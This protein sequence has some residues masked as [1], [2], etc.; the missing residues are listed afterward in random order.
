[1]GVSQAAQQRIN[2]EKQLIEQIIYNPEFQLDGI[3]ALPH[4]DFL[5]TNSFVQQTA[6]RL[7]AKNAA[8]KKWFALNADNQ[9]RLILSPETT[10]GAQIFLKDR[11]FTDAVVMDGV[12]LPD[13]SAGTHVGI[14]ISSI[15]RKSILVD[16]DGPILVNFQLSNDDTNWYT[17]VDTSDDEF[18]MSVDNTKKAIEFIDV[19]H[20]MRLVITNTSGGTRIVT[21]VIEGLT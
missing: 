10:P 20:F 11:N 15:T 19:A 3:Q 16:S 4:T 18:T 1:M 7:F 12:S 13:N 21:A 14:N 17:V 5:R 2:K 8:A 9:G 6:T